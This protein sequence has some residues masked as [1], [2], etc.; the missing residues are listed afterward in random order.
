[1]TQACVREERRIESLYPFLAPLKNLTIILDNFTL[2]QNISVHDNHGRIF[3]PRLLLLNPV[4]VQRIFLKQETSRYPLSAP[5]NIHVHNL[6]R[7]DLNEIR[8]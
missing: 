3:R 5:E 8:I 1:M 4:K 7:E 2:Y 6:F